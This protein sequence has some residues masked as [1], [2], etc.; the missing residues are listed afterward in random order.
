MSDYDAHF[1]AWLVRHH[2][3]MSRT[4]QH[5]D[6]SDPDV[7]LEFAR[8]VGDQEHLDNLY[9]LTVADMRGTSPK[10][11]NAWKGRLL[12]QLYSATTRMLRRG[13]ANPLKIEE[14][15]ADLKKEA[16]AVLERSKIPQEAVERHW[17]TLDEDYFLRH[18]AES[19]A[20]HAERIVP[21]STIDLPLVASRYHPEHQGIEFMIFAPARSDLFTTVT[22]GID[23]MNF[24]IVDARLHLSRSGLALDTFVVLPREGDTPTDR[25]QLDT[26]QMDLREQILSPLPGRDPRH[27]HLPRSMKHF[28][29]PT[30]VGF[31]VS[32]SGQS[33]LM[34][35][36]AQDRPGLLHQVARALEHCSASLLTAKVATYGARAED[37]FFLVDPDGGPLTNPEQI[38]CLKREIY[39]RLG[40]GDSEEG[41]RGSARVI[42][43]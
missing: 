9:L 43:F 24:S 23:R 13:V 29:I 38:V 25:K 22:G 39:A 33:T 32:S 12:S 28:P 31:S 26:M 11:W 21:S 5:E 8:A 15:I 16:L 42:E 41:A 20:W 27:S 4:A 2:L 17:H 1:V 7:V 6:I 3:S 36:T 34:E 18:D 30:K 19:I 35:V 10:V 37:V 40:G 14:R